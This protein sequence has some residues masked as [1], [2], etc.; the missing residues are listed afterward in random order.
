MISA[1]SLVLI[2]NCLFPVSAI[3]CHSSKPK[4]AF[5]KTA[6]LHNSIK[7]ALMGS[8]FTL[9]LVATGNTKCTS[10]CTNLL[11]LMHAEHVPQAS[12]DVLFKQYKYWTKAIAMA[13]L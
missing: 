5:C 3:S 4:Y 7:L 10:G 8:F 12:S 2:S 1:L 13:K 11:S 6:F 9:S